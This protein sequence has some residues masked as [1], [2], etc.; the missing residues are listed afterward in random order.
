MSYELPARR[1]SRKTSPTSLNVSW[2][3]NHQG[4]VVAWLLLGARSHHV[5]TVGGHAEPRPLALEVPLSRTPVK[6]AFSTGI[7]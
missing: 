4:R 1:C 2:L 3:T 7:W 6:W 5:P